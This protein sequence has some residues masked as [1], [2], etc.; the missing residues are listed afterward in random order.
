MEYYMK[1]HTLGFTLYFF[2]TLGHDLGVSY[3]IWER[4]IYGSQAI[5]SL[6]LA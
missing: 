6:P 5:G 3:N 1:I 2:V 4:A